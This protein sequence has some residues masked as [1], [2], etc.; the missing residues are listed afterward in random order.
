M[1]IKFH[2]I[3]QIEMGTYAFEKAVAGA[4]TVNGAFGSV[5]S[6]VFSVGADAKKA[7]MN[8]EVG[9]DAG[10]DDYKIY[11]D[12]TLRVVDFTKLDGELIE[13]YGT[14][15]DGVEVGT[16]LKSDASGKL[17]TGAS[18]APCFEVIDTIETSGG[19]E[20]V[21]VKVTMTDVE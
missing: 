16:K 8:V 14:L 19:L 11:K 15:P 20:G 9:D 1:L 7:I 5:S 17:I 3:G 6:G 18:A 2:T 4:D 10:L 12:Q 13:I 21:V